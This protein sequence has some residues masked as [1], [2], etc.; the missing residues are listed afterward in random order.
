MKERNKQNENQSE[1][2]V[3]NH[4]YF[5]DKEIVDTTILDEDSIN[6]NHTEK[7]QD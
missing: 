1:N 3:T 7:G 2:V 4:P 6:V 5:I